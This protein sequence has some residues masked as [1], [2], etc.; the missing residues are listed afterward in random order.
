M[1]QTPKRTKEEI[2]HNKLVDWG[3]PARVYDLKTPLYIREVHQNARRIMEACEVR[4]KELGEVL[5][6]TPEPRTEFDVA[7]LR[8]ARDQLHIENDKLRRL[9]EDLRIQNSLLQGK[10][11]RQQKEIRR[12][13]SFRLVCVDD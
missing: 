8:H 9:V 12:L 3:L 11:E 4:L 2:A 6:T 5:W 13:R 7:V 1:R 10:C